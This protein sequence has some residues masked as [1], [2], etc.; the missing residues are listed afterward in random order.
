MLS[1]LPCPCLAGVFQFGRL[2]TPPFFVI[3]LLSID[4][5]RNATTAHIN[6]NNFVLASS[7]PQIIATTPIAH[8]NISI[9]MQSNLPLLYPRSPNSKEWN[10]RNNIYRVRSE[11]ETLAYHKAAAEQVE[12]QREL[13]FKREADA[14]ES[15]SDD[16]RCCYFCGQV[17]CVLCYFGFF[18]AE[19][20][21]E[22]SN[23]IRNQ[24]KQNIM[25]AKYKVYL[26]KV[27]ALQKKQGRSPP[28]GKMSGIPFCVHERMTNQYP[29]K[30]PDC[31]QKPCLFLQKIHLFLEDA[32]DRGLGGTP[33]LNIQNFVKKQFAVINGRRVG[34]DGSLPPCVS[35][36]LNLAFPLLPDD[37]LPGTNKEDDSDLVTLEL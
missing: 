22:K 13:Q 8:C 1:L 23:R 33:H 18:E 16:E 25:S 10:P 12:R 11:E 29:V 34:T 26:A 27:R 35:N 28:C 7:H 30:C 31:K 5:C 24:T 6:T 15:D 21:D 4:A 19:M 32:I 9:T 17:R 2:L 3:V 20:F 37:D 36:H 14:L